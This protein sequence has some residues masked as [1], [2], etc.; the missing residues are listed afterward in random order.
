MT[1]NIHLIARIPPKSTQTIDIDIVPAINF[2]NSPCFEY[3]LNVLTC[4]AGS[5]Y[6]NREKEGTLYTG[7]CSIRYNRLVSEHDL[8]Y[9]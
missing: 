7:L 6:C 3:L 5:V 1:K 8:F 2:T 4:T 9:Q